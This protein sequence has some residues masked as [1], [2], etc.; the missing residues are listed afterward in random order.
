MLVTAQRPAAGPPQG[1]LV[2]CH[3]RGTSEQDLLPW[4][5]V[6]DREHRLHVVA[7]R[8]PL[9]IPGWPGYHWYRVPRVG[10]PER[11]SFEASCSALAELQDELWRSTGLGPDRTVLGGFS[12]GT[13][14]SYAMGLNPDRP[15]VAGI[16]AFSGFVPTVEGWHPEL[17]GRE[18]TQV[19]I[20]H[21]RADPVIGVEFGR[22]ARDLLQA[23][24]LSVEYRE[25]DAAHNIELDDVARGAAWLRELLTP[26]TAE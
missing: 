26:P 9:Q 13:V 12:M 19:L 15:A 4:A 1:L 10:D 25:S 17:Q 18:G 6:L 16:L 21:G 20:A 8:G 14:M 22:R 11:E 2:L 23:G 24:G 7:P 5:D 3:G